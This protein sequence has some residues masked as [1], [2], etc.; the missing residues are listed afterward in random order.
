VFNP[1]RPNNPEVIFAV[2]FARGLNPAQGSFFGNDVAPN[3]PVG[4]QIL[5]PGTGT[6]NGFFHLTRDLMSA[7]EQGDT[8]KEAIDS[9]Q[10][11]TRKYYFTT[12][13]F[14]PKI[15]RANDH[16]ND[17][18]VL[19]YAD[20]LLMLAE[21]QNE[22][23][24]ASAALPFVNSVRRRAG[25]SG[26]PETITQPELRLAIE[27]ERQVEFF[28]EGH[29]W[30]DLVRTGRAITVMN[31]HFEVYKDDNFETGTNSMISDYELLFPLPFS[32]VQL[33]PDKLAQNPGYN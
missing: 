29:R 31:R 11:S 5:A 6:G 12:K 33:N 18:I 22:L 9:A 7:F 16:A 26:L 23:G 2:Q 19:R 32:E 20:V 21:A 17:W 24:N 4:R 30:F 27:K 8:R 3:E 28:A 10:S 15:A 14:D 13:Y 1:D 25:L